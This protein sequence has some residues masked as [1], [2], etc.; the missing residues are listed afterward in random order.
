MSR[1][2]FLSEMFIYCVCV[3]F[4]SL[5]KKNSENLGYLAFFR[6]EQIPVNQSVFELAT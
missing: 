3:L 5:V 6:I 4:I 1:V 2:P